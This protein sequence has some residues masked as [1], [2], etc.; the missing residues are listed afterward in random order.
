MDFFSCF[1]YSN[2]FIWLLL[3]GQTPAPSETEMDPY[4]SDQSLS[5]LL[6]KE[7]LFIGS[8]GWRMLEFQGAQGAGTDI[9]WGCTSLGV[10]VTRGRN[11]L[12]WPISAT[13]PQDQIFEVK[14]IYTPACRRSYYLR[15]NLNSKCKKTPA[16]F[17]QKDS[18]YACRWSPL[19][20]DSRHF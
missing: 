20:L 8:E 3:L 19:F 4:S 17:L 10:Y 2:V 13:F 15:I 6:Q 16:L 1:N 12:R 5:L 11:G 18:T 7:V 14:K 9:W